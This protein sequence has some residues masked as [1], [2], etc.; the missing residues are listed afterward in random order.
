MHSAGRQI[1]A[2]LQFGIRSH[3][4]RPRHL[5]LMIAGFAIAAVT[6]SLMLAIPAG[7]ERNA[8]ATGRS[9]V[10]IVLQGDARS[11]IGSALSPDIVDIVSNLPGIARD[12][13]G[14]PQVAPQYLAS[15]QLRARDGAPVTVQLRG[16]TKATWE[17]LG[18]DE[19]Q[20][21]PAGFNPNARHLL[22]GPGAVH[23]LP[24]ARFG[25]QIKVRD[26]LWRV[27]GMIS[28]GGMWDSE[29][30]C[31]LSTLQAAFNAPSAVS[32]LWLKLARPDALAQIAAAIE[33]DRR[34]YGVRVQSQRAYYAGKV[35][36]LSHYARIAAAAVALFLGLGA[37]IA[38][39]T[40][41]SL[42]LEGRRWELA[43]LRAL[44][45]R[46]PNLAIALFV[47]VLLVALGTTFLVTVIVQWLTSGIRLATS[48]GD[49]SF[50]FQMAVTPQVF[51]WVLGY[52]AILSLLSALLPTIQ[53]IREPLVRA[54]GRG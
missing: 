11:E 29:F 9:D 41:V 22:A 5:I 38:V 4:S 42:A 19:A 7:L 35:R 53:M 36:A 8:G 39:G 37:I 20:I 52:V 3:A 43:T 25:A 48:T 26:R 23:I 49:H 6:L 1:L 27:A 54:L 33:K 40:A 12:K 10:A 47:E 18:L 51:A 44:G 14:N 45:F 15:M 28:P 30:W 13:N 16:I 32:V 24:S 50:S 31:G 17:L 21:L 46:G 2:V 34:L